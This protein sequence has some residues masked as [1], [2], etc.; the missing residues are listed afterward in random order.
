MA[1]P[2]VVVVTGASAGAGRAAVRLF[3]RKGA[4]VALIARGKDGL[5]AAKREVESYG[6]RALVLPTD[7]SDADA[8]EKAADSA[9]YELGPID[10]WV[11][12]AMVSVF[13]P[14]LEMTPAEFKRV[15]EVTY[16]GYVYGTMSALKRMQTRNRGTIVQVGSALAYRS[17]PLQA[18]Y[19]GAKH[20]IAGFTDSIRSEL[21]H[22]N[23]KVHITMVHLPAMN[24]PQFDWCRTKLPGNPQ[25]VPPIYQPEVAA[26]A[27]V[28]ASSHRRREVYVGWPTVKAIYGQQVAPSYA[29]RY[30]A[31]NAYDGQ[32]TT[33]PVSPQRPDN[34]FE[35]A[36]GDYSAHGR[37]DD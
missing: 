30:L 27:I 4:D 17:I 3:A 20:G 31:K 22:Q 7:V 19:C 34:L 15:T 10:V 36:E 16:L 23:S 2:K 26:R 24:T 29:D 21:E 37:F 28:W 14:F 5:E 32:Q 25:P 1:F 13:S 12:V 9:E 33:E 35:P 11:N 18:A 8:V 6:R